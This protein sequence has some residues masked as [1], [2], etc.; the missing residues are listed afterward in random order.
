MR[1]KLD[2]AQD[3]FSKGALEA[4]R[5]KGGGTARAYCPVTV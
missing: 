2:G 5:G 3:A 1:P 4:E